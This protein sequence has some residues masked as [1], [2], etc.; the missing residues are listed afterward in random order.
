MTAVHRPS[1]RPSGLRARIAAILDACVTALSIAAPVVD[2][3]VRLS[4]AK[5]F[6]DPGMLPHI[7]ALD[8][9]RSDWAAIAVQVCG[10]LLL[11]V[12]FLVRPVALLMLV[13]TLVAQAGA[14]QDI[15]LFWAA[16]FGWYVV[17][18][19]GALSLDHV[20]G[21]GLGLSPLPLAGPATAAADWF[22]R[23]IAPLYRLALRLWL[24]AA[25]V[26][27]V[28]APMMLPGMQAGMLP[29]PVA[30]LAALCLTLG[31]GTPV[32]AVVLLAASSG[33]AAMGLDQG[34][35][36]YGPLLLAL[37]GVSGAGR[38]SL[39]RLIIAMANR[40]VAPADD[41]PHIVIIGAGFGGMACAEGLRHEQARVTL[42]DQ[43]NFHLFQPL[44]YQ[45]ATG[46]LSPADIA[47]PIRG[48]FRDNLGITVLCGTVSGID[49]AARR[50]T[51]DGRAIP[52]DTLVLATGASHG[53]FGHEEWAEYAPGLKSVQDATA[54]RS[55]V[56]DAFE[57]AEATDD[58]TA[59]AALLTFLVCGA[60]PTGVELAGAI[61]ELSRNGMD[62][63]FRHIDPS[64]ARILLVQAGPR[65]LPQFDE[66]LSAFA[67]KSLERL[68]VEVRVDSRVEAIDAQGVTVNGQHI[69]AA[70]VL[71]AAGVV[72][73]PAASWL[74]VK[75]DRAGRIQVGPD[76]SVPGLPDVFA[77]GDTALSLAW[78]GNPVPG[79]A[80][81]AKQG[82]A[83]VAAVMRARLRG[84][85]PPPPFRYRHQG[86]L[87]TI[88][89]KSAIADFGW[90][91]L[92]GALAWW[93][94]GAVHILFLLSMRN[95]LSVM[96]GWAWSYFTFGIGVRLITEDRPHPPILPEPSPAP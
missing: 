95:R 80:A 46:N 76:L 39:D 20:L 35:T 70:T 64:T 81:A 24:A 6:F 10:P 65:V 58:P 22:D 33:A 66:R 93:L 78:N 13:L 41:A 1:G 54:I 37:L 94:W 67:R 89:R 71:W 96:L 85:K 17:Q 15:H 42:V 63:E 21:K 86:S 56:L 9:L 31:L 8:A 60:G 2:L 49:P 72:A 61:A 14:P 23:Q 59:R 87:A 30:L 44:L 51:V 7:H 47:T 83:Y 34:M 25:I 3:L 38:Y 73:S 69:P 77:I 75:P 26:G 53:Y 68:G 5:A 52:Y 84:R 32:V 88:G 19:A 62:K 16:L 92:T 43:H 36:I 4:L 18:G 55:R 45:V 40:R 48:V 79:L 57:R 27:T 74:G 50:V 29:R 11:T 91:K 90:I 28:L 12:G 82:G